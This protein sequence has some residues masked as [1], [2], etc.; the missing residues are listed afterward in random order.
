[1]T[2]PDFFQEEITWYRALVPPSKR[3]DILQRYPWLSGGQ[4]EA[5]SWEISFN[6]AGIPIHFAAS[7]RVVEKPVLSWVKPSPYP[8]ALQTRGYIQGS[9][10]IYSLS[11]E[12]ERY[13]DLISPAQ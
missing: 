5:K 9:G 3:M 7:E 2:V 11:K 6:Q 13:L 1:L 10:P 12:G 4:M 8:Y